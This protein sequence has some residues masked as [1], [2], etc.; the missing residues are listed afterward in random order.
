MA[1]KCNPTGRVAVEAAFTWDAIADGVA[2][3]YTLTEP[4]L[5]PGRD[6]RAAHE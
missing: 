1:R 3:V 2:H 5:R 6:K 4:E